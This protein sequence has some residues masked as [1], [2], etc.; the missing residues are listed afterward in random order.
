MSVY[1]DIL[2]A[3][4]EHD[5]HESDLYVPDNAEVRQIL[6]RHVEFKKNAKPFKDKFTGNT[7]LD[8]PFAYDPF[9]NK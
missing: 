2:A 9:Y 5:H 4:I 3:R 8:I 7:W 6:D 1:T